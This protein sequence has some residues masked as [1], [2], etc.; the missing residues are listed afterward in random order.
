[1]EILS[2]GEYAGEV[3]LQAQIE[4]VIITHIG[5]SLKQNDPN[6]HAHE[7]L[8]FCLVFQ[9]GKADTKKTTKYADKGGSIFFYHAGEMHRWITH[10]PISKGINIEIG[11]AFLR[12]YH[13]TENEIRVALNQAINAK[14]LMLKIQQEVSINE[15]DSCLAVNSLLLE[16]VSEADRITSTK[17]PPIWVQQITQFLEDNWNHEISLS[18]IAQTLQVH[19]VT[20]SKNFRKYF[21][22]TLGEYRRKLKIERSIG[23]IKTSREPLTQIALQ[24]G[25][26]DQ[27]HFIRNFKSYTGFLPKEFRKY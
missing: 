14:S 11:P 9:G 23:L 7:N 22:C 18:D 24:S 26:A 13:T 19:A 6:W 25:F 27:S 1:M 5:Y 20:I 17:N 2:S 10:E 8:H 15:L 12:K 21:G 3:V 16:L 4:D